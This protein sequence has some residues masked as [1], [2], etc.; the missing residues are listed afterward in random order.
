MKEQFSADL[1]G[2]ACGAIRPLLPDY[3]DQALPAAD[4]ARVAAHLPTC[5]ACQAALAQLNTLLNDLDALPPLPP[6]S[7][8]REDFMAM[9]QREKAA[10]A[11]TKAEEY[12]PNLTAQPQETPSSEARTGR[13]VPL[14]GPPSSGW[15]RLAASVALVLVGLALGL[16]VRF[17]RRPEVAEVQATPASL[18]VQLAAAVREPAAATERLQLVGE[19]PTHVQP[20]D[21]A[22]QALI[23]TLDTDPN[24]NVRLA[25]CEALYH[26]RADPRVGPALVEALP[27]QTDPNVQITL[28]E[29][30]VRLRET[31]AV[32][33]LQR[34]AQRP[35]ALPVV[36]QQAE[37]G[38]GLLI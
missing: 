20:G 2:P 26:L 32:P 38:V 13:V 10:L 18:S 9:L 37:S 31:R 29:L 14:W 35:D 36:R 16:T 17:G 11:A 22:V 15:L 12:L 5:P 1:L 3:A 21:P 28:I 27:L 33:H 7:A 25:A 6:P 30:L 19:A 8:L 34:L 4:L 24:P 23:H